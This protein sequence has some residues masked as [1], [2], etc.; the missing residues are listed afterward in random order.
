MMNELTALVL[1]WQQ[2]TD[3]L[4]K[5]VLFTQ[6]YTRVQDGMERKVEHYR[7]AINGDMLEGYSRAAECLLTT[8]EKFEYQGHS[9]MSAYVVAVDNK[10]KDLIRFNNSQKAGTGV[11][12]AISLDKELSFGDG[13]QFE[14]IEVLKA[15]SHIITDDYETEA[16]LTIVEVLKAYAVTKPFEA[17]VIDLMITYSGQAYLKSDLTNAFAAYYGVAEYKQVQ[18]RV[19]RVRA[20]FAKFAV[21]MGYN[22]PF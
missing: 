20:N 4:K 16:E 8:M 7:H 10:M 14:A 2:E 12:V 5:D 18:R 22:L 3:V 11:N 17:G 9:F 6:V 13:E 19:S 21:D 15:E 1:K